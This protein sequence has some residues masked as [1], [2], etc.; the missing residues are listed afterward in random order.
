MRQRNTPAK[1]RALQE[2]VTVFIVLMMLVL[3]L[4]AAMSFATVSG[5][6]LL[7]SGNVSTKERAIQAAEV[8]VNTAFAAIQAIGNDNQPAAGWYRPTDQ[9]RTPENLPPGVDWDSAPEIQVGTDGQFS[10]RYFVDR[11]CI[12]ADVTDPETQ[13]LLKKTE[14][15][16][17]AVEGKCDGDCSIAVPGGKQ[18]RITVRVVSLGRDGRPDT[19]TFVQSLATKA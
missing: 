11:Q 3:M 17:S 8:G 7:I 5:T 13:C 14:V 1:P 6:A 16:K 18:F 19:T 4:L 12:V 10:V 9:G 2:G 15:K